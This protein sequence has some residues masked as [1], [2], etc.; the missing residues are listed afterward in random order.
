[1]TPVGEGD[2][3]LLAAPL[4]VGLQLLAYDLSGLVPLLPGRLSGQLHSHRQRS[5]HSMARLRLT[6][7]T[8]YI[9]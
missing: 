7:L 8:V 2:L 1:M 4:V 3:E 5:Q 6:S 9:T